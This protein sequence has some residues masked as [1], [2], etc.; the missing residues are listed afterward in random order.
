LDSIPA[1]VVIGAGVVGGSIALALA[2]ERIPVT[3]LDRAPGPGMGSTSAS[4]AIVR[5]HYSTYEGV[6]VA[7]E[8]KHD[9]EDWPAYL[10][11]TDDAGTA[12]YIR[13][14][15]LVLDTPGYDASR[16]LG[17]YESLGIPYEQLSAAAIRARFPYLST[18]RF[19]P[20][21]SPSD[22]VFWADAT[23]EL[24]G[25]FTPEGGFVDDPGLAA[26]NLWTAATAQGAVSMFRAEVAEVRR[27]DS[28][29]AGVTLADG[30]RVDAAIVINAA[31]PHSS[32]VN[33]FAGV[34]DDFVVST[35][36]MRQEVHSVGGPPELAGE[37]GP[38]VG[39]GD[40]GTYFRFAPGG[41]VLVGSQE[42]DCDPLEWLDDADDCDVRPTVAGFERQTL[43]LARRMPSVSLPHRPVGLAGVYDVTDDWIPIYDKTSLPGFYVAIGT[44]GNQFKNA[45]AIGPMMVSLITDWLAGGDH[46]TSRVTWTAPRTGAVVDLGHYSRLRAPHAESSNSV[47]G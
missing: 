23:G 44:S 29:V 37:I 1:A 31:G 22:E 19:Y 5:F 30:R 14:G 11:A 12:R 43:R 4:S 39:D 24:G 46:D 15:A 26:H 8:A 9:W 41:R 34:L 38:T 13:T 21:R 2:R 18:E 17:H 47:L 36:P 16:V 3:I 35:R 45:P 33:A 40:L 32:N 28:G 10:G 6:A 7:W 25:F 20:P 42:P 27:D